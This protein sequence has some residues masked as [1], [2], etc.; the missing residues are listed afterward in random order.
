MSLLPSSEG[1]ITRFTI[2]KRERDGWIYMD[3]DSRFLGCQKE[4]RRNEGERKTRIE[5]IKGQDML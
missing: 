4:R 2:D 3:A 1:Q 5:M